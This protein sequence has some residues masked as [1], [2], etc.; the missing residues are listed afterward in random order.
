VTAATAST[1]ETKVTTPV[2]SV[3]DLRLLVADLQREYPESGNRPEKA[4]QIFTYRPIERSPSGAWY[5]G[6]ESD[7]DAEYIVAGHSCTCQ[8]Y[9]RRAQACKHLM[10]V[11]LYQRAERLEAEADID[12]DA[13]I[14]LWLTE[15][16]LATLDGPRA[17]ATCIRCSQPRSS[18]HGELCTDCIAEELF[19]PKLA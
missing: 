13:P 2:I 19:G 6:S 17:I 14:D 9:K 15:L 10:S 5:V 12:A 8:D 18:V 3:D 7:P 1:T 11:V 4:G 16:A